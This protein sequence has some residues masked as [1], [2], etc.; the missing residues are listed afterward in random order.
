MISAARLTHLKSLLALARPGLQFPDPMRW[1]N[2]VEVLSRG[3]PRGRPLHVT[4]SARSGLVTARSLAHLHRLQFVAREFFSHHRHRPSPDAR[5]FSMALAAVDLP[6]LSET[7]A[8]LVSTGKTSRVQV[9]HEVMGETPLRFTALVEQNGA[10]GP[11]SIGKDKLVTVGDDV[12]RALRTLATASAS[13]AAL[14]LADVKGLTVV[15]VIRGELGPL[16]FDGTPAPASSSLAEHLAPLVLPGEAVL[17]VTLQ[18]VAAD[19]ASDT[20]R[21]FLP[22]GAPP[23]PGLKLAHERRLFC[24][25]ALEAPLKAF[26]DRRFL[27]RA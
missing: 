16:F 15:E 1:R 4:V 13:E 18:R 21:D 27:V 5:A 17:S 8:R 6:P 3:G 9:V 12:A 22:A 24:T 26:A 10:R 11:L 7:T 2:L 23:V 20:C 19:V 14:V 25:R